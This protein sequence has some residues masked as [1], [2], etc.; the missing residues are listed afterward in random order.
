MSGDALDGFSDQGY[1]V[2]RGLLDADEV[3]QAREI[4]ARHLTGGDAEEMFTSDF[5]ADDFLTEIVLRERVVDAARRLLGPRVVLYPNATARR[6][7]YVPWH[8]D[9]TFIGP[10]ARHVWTPGFVHVQGGLYLQD[11]DPSHGG[12]V[13]V[14]AG[15]HLM[16]FDGYGRIPADFSVADRTLGQSS[17][18]RTV[19]T[20]AGDLLLWH[21]R[22]MHR[23]TPAVT[24]PGRDKLGI[25]FSYGRDDLSDNHRFLQQIAKD[26]VRTMNGISRRIPRLTEISRFRYPDGF[27]AE[28]VKKAENAGVTVVSL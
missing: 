13:D 10:D 7:S 28:F 14:I 16:S 21:G 1:T 25:F 27:P 18:R 6:N 24:A 12:G 11:N 8:V 4:C 19:G 22:L 15:S 9:S 17:L 2:L 26:S 5:L 3:R 23:S 20:R